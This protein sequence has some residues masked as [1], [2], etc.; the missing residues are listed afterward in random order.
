VSGQV[1]MHTEMSPPMLEAP[2]KRDRASTF[3]EEPIEGEIVDEE[4]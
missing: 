1:K 3:R 4:E 2:R